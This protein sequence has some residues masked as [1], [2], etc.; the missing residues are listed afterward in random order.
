MKPL[1]NFLDS[2]PV[3]LP[4]SAEMKQEL[5][6]I[7]KTPS[8]NEIR[9]TPRNKLTLIFLFLSIHPEAPVAKTKVLIFFSSTSSKPV[10]SDSTLRAKFDQL[11]TLIDNEKEKKRDEKESQKEEIKRDPEKEKLQ[12]IYLISCFICSVIT[13]TK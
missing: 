6:Y 13:I 8:Y 10:Q 9:N 3:W 1:F 7:I 2:V 12:I 4:P 5:K 11:K